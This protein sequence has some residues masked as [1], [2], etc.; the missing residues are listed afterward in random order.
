MATAPRRA[1][2][3]LRMRRLLL[4]IV[5]LIIFLILIF[6]LILLLFGLPSHTQPHSRLRLAPSLSALI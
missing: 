2:L 1:R 5:L 4:L 6:L 3:A